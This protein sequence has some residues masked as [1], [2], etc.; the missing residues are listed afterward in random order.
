[1]VQEEL[2]EH[3]GA[4][5]I[6]VHHSCGHQRLGAAEVADLAQRLQLRLGWQSPKD[7]QLGASWNQVR[8]RQE[9]QLTPQHLPRC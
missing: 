6:G 2:V 1:M 4:H 8:C 9:H 7:V 5:H 3:A